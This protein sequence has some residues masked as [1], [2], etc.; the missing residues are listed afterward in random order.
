MTDEEDDIS[1]TSTVPSEPAYEYTVD[2]VLA[3]R[4]SE[5]GIEYLVRWEGYPVDRSTWEPEESFNDPQTLLDWQKKKGLIE[6]GKRHPF[7][8]ASFERHQAKLE[9]DSLNRKRRRAAKRRRLGLEQPDT[10]Q[11]ETS[12]ASS[13][14][15]EPE[16]EPERVPVPPPR[17][18]PQTVAHRPTVPF[19]GRVRSIA[20]KPPMVGF[21]RPRGAPGHPRPAKPTEQEPTERFR[22]LSTQ[23]KHNKARAKEPVPDINQLDLRRPSEWLPRNASTT[24]LGQYPISSP[25]ATEPIP[26]PTESTDLPVVRRSTISVRTNAVEQHSSKP[27]DNVGDAI[28]PQKS[29]SPTIRQDLSNEAT[30]GSGLAIRGLASHALAAKDD[31]SRRQETRTNEPIRLPSRRPKKNSY[32][33]SKGR[34][35]NPGE[36]LVHLIYGSHKAYIGAT[37]F[38]GLPQNAKQ[39]ILKAKT[40]YRFELWFEHICTLEQY[41]ML[42]KNVCVTPLMLNAFYFLYFD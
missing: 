17:P 14:E 6:A 40:T 37:R 35:I 3:E 16:N 20:D 23:H 2:A 39:M 22:L 9:S 32:Q 38:C 18:P 42:S 8:V 12:I 33:I 10:L 11:L 21:G 30:E 19:T 26:A 31:D 28:P 4:S 5:N 29:L 24:N 7:D 1:I 15:S 27:S 13:P 41:R 25:T 34:F 36:I